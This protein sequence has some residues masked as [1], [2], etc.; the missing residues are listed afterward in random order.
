MIIERSKALEEKRV[1]AI[2]R[3]RDKRG[4]LLE[5][6]KGKLEAVVEEAAQEIKQVLA[7]LKAGH[8]GPRAARAFGKV[9]EIGSRA[10]RRLQKTERYLPNVGDR[11]TIIGSRTKGVVALVDRAAERAE[12]SVGSLKVWVDWKKLKPSSGAPHKKSKGAYINV[13]IEVSTSVNLIGMRAAEA[14]KVL[15]RFLDNAHANG[16]DRVEV[17]HGVGTGRLAGA[18]K[19]FLN[20]SELVKRFYHGDPARGGGGVTV[21]ELA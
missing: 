4:V 8:T 13:D 3:L 1:E 11:V 15:T 20:E 21:V 12:L 9:E 6:I 5:K 10:A 17:I 19:G 16:L 18:V 2:E 7:E 14:I